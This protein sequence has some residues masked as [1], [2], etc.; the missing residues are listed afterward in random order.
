QGRLVCVNGDREDVLPGID[1]HAAFD[2]HTWGSMYVQVRNDLARNSANA[3]VFAGD[4]VY[5]Y[6]NLRGDD[7]SDPQYIPAGLATGS[8]ENLVMTTDAMLKAVDGNCH[9]VIPV[10][11][12]R[13]KDLYP[14]RI[15]KTGLRI[16][17]LALADGEASKVR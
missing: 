14:S 5:T 13:L 16:T 17:E 4:L 7:A 15:T 9:R 12:E 11:E 2:T 3:W 8:Q 6:E 10:H 1:L